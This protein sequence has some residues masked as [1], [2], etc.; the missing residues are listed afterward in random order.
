MSRW[1]RATVAPSSRVMAASTHTA[2]CQ[3]L[4]SV[5]N[6]ETNTRSRAANPPAL[7]TAAMK[8]VAGLGEPW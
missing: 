3:S 6:D 4:R 2:G 1:A 7:A 8:P 5:P